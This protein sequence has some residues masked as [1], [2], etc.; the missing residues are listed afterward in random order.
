MTC[1]CMG[2]I[3]WLFCATRCCLPAPRHAAPG[4][5][6]GPQLSWRRFWRRRAA[7]YQVEW[8]GQ[9]VLVR[10]A[11][12]RCYA[13]PSL[14]AALRQA[15]AQGTS[16]Q[17]A[18]AL[19]SSAP[20]CAATHKEQLLARLSQRSVFAAGAAAGRPEPRRPPWLARSRT[21][22]VAA[23]PAT[24]QQL[25]IALQFLL[26]F[27]AVMFL[28]IVDASYAALQTRVTWAVSTAR[29]ACTEASRA[30]AVLERV[31]LQ[32]LA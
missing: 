19:A 9:L 17:H 6:G 2:G 22:L 29:A 31:L 30:L 16:C 7:T 20:P 10:S 24:E 1:R 26:C 18:V 15:S 14:S 4:G 25:R 21:W 23:L 12:L 3:P 5:W 13:W 28:Q 11:W 32:V 27:L 8:A